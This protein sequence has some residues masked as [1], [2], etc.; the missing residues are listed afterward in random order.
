LAGVSELLEILGGPLA[1]RVG[2]SVLLTALSEAFMPV[3]S[4]AEA[5][6]LA[7]SPVAIPSQAFLVG[8]TSADF[9]A[10]GIDN[11]ASPKAAKRTVRSSFFICLLIYD[12]S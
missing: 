9:P 4:R 1:L 2:L 5:I 3:L 6:V 10:E 8:V 12:L 7:V 11:Q